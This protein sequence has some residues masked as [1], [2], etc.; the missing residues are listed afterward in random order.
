MCWS[1]GAEH[2]S[3]K[4]TDLDVK[5]V[6]RTKFGG[7]WA[8]SVVALT[9]RLEKPVPLMLCRRIGA[10]GVYGLV[11]KACDEGLLE[12]KWRPKFAP[13][14][15]K[16]SASSTPEKAGSSKSPRQE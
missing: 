1:A 7:A 14:G 16:R 5:E 8:R 4:S 12:E 15:G 6:M 2:I 13:K 11:C 3:Y 9:F 10:V